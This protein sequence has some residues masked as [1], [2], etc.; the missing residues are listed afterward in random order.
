MGGAWERMIGTARRILEALL[1]DISTKNLTHDILVTFMAEVCA[2]VN[3]RPIVPVGV[4]S[5]N[6]QIL[7]PSTILNQKFDHSTPVVQQLN[8][9]DIYKAEWKC[10][11]V[12]ADRFWKRW[13]AEYLP[14]LQTRPKWKTE[15]RNLKIG[16]IVLLKDSECVRNQWPLGI[17]EKV[18]T[19]DDEKVR[20]IS[21]KI[22]RHGKSTTFV[23]PVTEVV[24][25][26]RRE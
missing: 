4:D 8:V 20:K 18:Y 23:R 13:Q 3:A 21:V 11:Q 14:S 9:R 19:S 22:S 7:S 12:L 26:L 6:P 24:L 16:D 1:T 17:I 2:I 5:D 25:L 15:S 10:V